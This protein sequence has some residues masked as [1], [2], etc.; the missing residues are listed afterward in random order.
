M[1]RDRATLARQVDDGQV[2]NVYRL[3]I[4]NATESPQ[5]YS[6]AVHGLPGIVLGAVPQPTLAA[7]EAR[8][9]TLSVR[10]PAATAQQAG[11][12]AHAIQFEVGVIDTDVRGQTTTRAAVTEKSTFV[13]P[14]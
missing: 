3:Q 5:R 14:R 10:V 2:E 11:P 8:W 6:V 1:G 4:M 13:V 7:A 12:G 9:V